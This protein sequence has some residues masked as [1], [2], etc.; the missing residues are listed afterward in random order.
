MIRNFTIGAAFAAVLFFTI[1]AQGAMIELAATGTNVE[2]G[3]TFTIDVIARDINLGGYQLQL[4]FDPLLATLTDIAFGD[5][6][7]APF[8]FADGFATIDEIFLDEVSFAD[9]SLLLDLQGASTGNQFRLARLTF[10]ALSSGTASF[11]ILSA[12]LSDFDGNDAT[13]E[14]SGVSIDISRGTTPPPS[15]VPEPGTYVLLAGGLGLIAAVKRR[16]QR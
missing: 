2:V 15:D 13:A 14:L 6:L 10:Q 4:N 8:S 16:R 7:G 11:D 12:I 3:E 5:S 9:S 1:P